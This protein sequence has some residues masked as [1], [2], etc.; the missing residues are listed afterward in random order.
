MYSLLNVKRN[1]I[2][3]K[4]LVNMDNFDGIMADE[5]WELLLLEKP[6]TKITFI[7]DFT[8]EEAERLR[9]FLEEVEEFVRGY[10]N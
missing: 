4:E 10:F 8:K 3:L 2:R 7:T 5:F 9:K 1:S 6:A